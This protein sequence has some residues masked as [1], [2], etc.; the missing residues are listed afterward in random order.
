MRLVPTTTRGRRAVR[1]VLAG[2]AAACAALAALDLVLGRPDGA[3]PAALS[4]ILAL[5]VR[6]LARAER[7]RP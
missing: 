2:L 6:A 7:I 5:E 3:I 4:G 1:R